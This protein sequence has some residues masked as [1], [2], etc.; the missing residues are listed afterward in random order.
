VTETRTLLRERAPGKI[1]LCLFL[2]PIRPEDARHELVSVMQSVTL[3]DDVTLEPAAPGAAEDEVVCEGVTGPNLAAAAL[4]AFRKQTGWDGPPV[5]L[6]I[7][8]RVP[9]AAGMGGGSGDA[10][11][12]LRLAAR[13]AGNVLDETL[14]GIAADL[15]A[16]VPAQ[17]RPGRSL[18]TGAGERV[19]ALSAG[20]PMGVLVL[21]SQHELSTR[22]VYA[23]AD[24]LGLPRGRAELADR[25]SAVRRALGARG[26]L[27]AELLVND[28]EPAA[29]SLLPAIGAAL[30]EARAAG[31]DHAMVAGSGPTVLGLF[32]AEEGVARARRAADAL[33]ARTPAP[34][35]A[36]PVA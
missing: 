29:R 14:L 36:E 19:E 23:E 18:A 33:A 11:A 12:A 24:R 21:P 25:A 10:A 3:A 7:D 17:V 9:L 26:E 1:N 35:V 32:L 2:G 27:P 34:I 20:A 28:L 5:R 8:K 15:G 22:D 31:A 4:A 13:A 16:D 6:T 30:D